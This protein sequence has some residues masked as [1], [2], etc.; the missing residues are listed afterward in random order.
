VTIA[1][2]DAAIQFINNKP[3]PLALYWFGK[4]KKNLQKVLQETRSGGVTINE[5]LLHA[6]VESLPF[7]GTGSSGIG[8]YH[9]KAGFDIF[10]HRK[11]I[12]QVRGFLGLNL[13][14]GSKLARPPY[15]KGVERL[16]RFLK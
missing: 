6:T 1:N 10:S 9:G 11:S 16:L 3:N 2:T 12:L 5:T 8:A 7:G 4:D 15:G 13:W 14:K